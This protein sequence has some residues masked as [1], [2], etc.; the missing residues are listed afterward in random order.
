MSNGRLFWDDY[1]PKEDCIEVLYVSEL[2]DKV[3]SAQA[4]YD[5]EVWDHE[6]LRDVVRA[7]CEE[8]SEPS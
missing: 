6:Q 3:E 5:N 7:F 8:C 4:D 1:D 2:E